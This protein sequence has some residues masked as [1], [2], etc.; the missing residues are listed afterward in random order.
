MLASACR[1]AVLELLADKPIA[2]F[3]ATLSQA[4]Q[5]FFDDRFLATAWYPETAS[6]EVLEK[7]AAALREPAPGVALR[8]GARTLDLSAG[9]FGRW[10]LQLFA[11]PERFAGYSGQVWSRLR[12][13]ELACRLEAETIHCELSNWRGHH[14]LSCLAVVGAINELGKNMRGVHWHGA[15]RTACVASGAS[16]CA[17]ELAFQ[18]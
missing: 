12:D 6:G 5:A 2:D 16:R 4:G 18:R 11:T 1:S 8:L 14:P 3:K 7:L 10:L 17:Y 13:G 9:Q 15:Q